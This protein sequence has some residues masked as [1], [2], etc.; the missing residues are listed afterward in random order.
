MRY[1]LIPRLS[2]FCGHR[3][4]PLA[5]MVVVMFGTLLSGSVAA[6]S[7]VDVPFSSIAGVNVLTLGDA[8]GPSGTSV[9]VQLA[10]ENEDPVKGIQFDIL[11]ESAK[12]FFSGAVATAR[13]SLMV[14]GAEQIAD[15]QAR[16]ILYFD[17]DDQ[18]APGS[19]D[20]AE[21]TFSLLGPG[22]EST[23]LILSGMILS[24]PAGN[25][26]TV[27][28]VDGLLTVENP[29]EVPGLQISALKNPGRVR[30]LQILV[31]VSNGSGSAPT[32]TAG[33]STVEMTSL[34]QAIYEGTYSAT[35]TA[36]SV[37]ISATDTNIVGTGTAPQTIVSF[38]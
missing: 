25:P 9:T 31:R 19:G 10:L 13:S 26:L 6:E 36:T 34:G 30:T 24:D 28:G 37:T 29:L 33:G 23:D 2:G 22:G 35:Q 18:L 17:T 16:I 5:G 12:A 21:V 32:V 14:I 38:Q 3:W 8:S 1:S 4:V 7:E 11:F 15:N 27:S 20:V